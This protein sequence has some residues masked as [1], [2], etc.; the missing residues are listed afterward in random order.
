METVEIK[1]IETRYNG[2]RFRSRLEARWAVFFD[3]ADIEYEYEPEGFV[4][5]DGTPYLPDFYL[6]M[7]NAYVE[8]KRKSISEQELD[9][10]EDKC[11]SLFCS[12]NG[13]VVLLCKGD[14]I[15][16]DIEIFCNCYD[17]EFGQLMS[18]EDCAVFVEGAF[19]NDIDDEGNRVVRGN[20]KHGISIAVG[21]RT[22]SDNF[23]FPY[24]NIFRLSA[25]REYRSTLQGCKIKSR[26]A[27]FERGETPT[28]QG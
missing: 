10:A 27:R 7:F 2:Y 14:P 26:A 4:L 25:M 11:A 3:A 16:M 18:W 6:P 21:E 15:D 5:K 8:I 23:S 12:N 19:W 1:A 24:N 22:Y 13:I 28:K 9:D 17:R 20:G